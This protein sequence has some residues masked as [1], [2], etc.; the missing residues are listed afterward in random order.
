M[1]HHI[2]PEILR[3]L[4]EVKLRSVGYSFNDGQMVTDRLFLARQAAPKRVYQIWFMR[5]LCE[6][7]LKYHSGIA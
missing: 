3:A 5:A 7:Q 2:Q 1:H 4:I 6:A